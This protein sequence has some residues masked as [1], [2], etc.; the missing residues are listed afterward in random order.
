M[1]DCARAMEV[2]DNTACA[3]Y[4]WLREVCSTQLLGI[5][6]KLGGVGQAGG[7]LLE[8]HVNYVS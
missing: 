4:Q 1:I 7:M 8:H 6:I 2:D 3:V 5:T